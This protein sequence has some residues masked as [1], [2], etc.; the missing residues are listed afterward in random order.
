M[1]I[2]SSPP[3]NTIGQPSVNFDKS[4]FDAAIWNK[5][6]E[7]LVE[8]ARPCPCRSRDSGSPLLTC[9][10]CRGFGWLFINPFKTRAIVT[11]VGKRQMYLEWS[12][13]SR[14]TISLTV[15]DIEKL[16]EYDKITFLSVISKR[17]EVLDVRT[18]GD[19]MFV[20]L[21]YKLQQVLDI[22]Y[23]KSAQE[24]LVKLQESEYSLVDDNPYVIEL[25]FTPASNFNNSVTVTYNHYPSYNIV[26]LPHDL[27]ASS[28]VNALGQIEKIDLPINAVARKSH[29]VLVGNDYGGTNVIDNSYK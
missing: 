20:F 7:V 5:G 21:S 1:S 19:K 17:G 4:N 8:E 9:Q 12:E 3:P 16:A 27:R 28:I 6:Y 26:D 11:G 14:G 29:I 13:E 24:P 15:R 2:R 23:F 18:Y 25:N 10:N 22:F